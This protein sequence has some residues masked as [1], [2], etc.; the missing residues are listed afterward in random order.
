MT[1]TASDFL[2]NLVGAGSSASV[3]AS[4]TGSLTKQGEGTLWLGASRF[5]GGTRIEGG[6]V[7]Q[8]GNLH[9]D[10]T[11][12]AGTTLEMYGD[13]IGDVDNHGILDPTDDYYTYYDA[14]IFG[15]Y[16]QSAEGLLRVLF[17]LQGTQP[18]TPLLAVTGTGT[19]DGTLEFRPSGFI[20]SGGYLEWVLHANGGVI[21][22]FDRWTSPG[23]FIEG[24]VRYGSNDVYLETT[25]V[26]VAA[27]MAANGVADAV[28]IASAANLDRSFASADR[29]AQA[30]TASLSA[31]QQQLL[32]SSA[33]IQRI[34]D[35]VQA[36][37]T[38]DSVS[39]H[40][41]ARA[42]GALHA[43]AATS[44]MQLDA[45]L[46]SLAHDPQAAPR[47]GALRDD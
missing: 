9:S 26:S 2:I 7:G 5:D 32:S 16:S 3:N 19:L 29:F 39:G 10:V 44:T 27:A 20:P 42:Q 31:S 30:P 12:A 46:L 41:H 21:G 28:T 24:N 43:Q 33:S 13:I 40:A 11:V 35:V 23:L 45:H 1:T 36:T 8:F 37:R 22:Q 4:T 17:G 34:A 47:D 18:A 6:I 25:R 14:E 38:L 15:N